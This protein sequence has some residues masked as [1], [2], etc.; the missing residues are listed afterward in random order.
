M[1][2][3]M[4]Q[5][6]LACSMCGQGFTRKRSANRHNL[7]LHSGQALVVRTIEY[8]IG[9]VNGTFPAAIDPLLFRKAHKRNH[10]DNIST[11]ARHIYAHDGPVNNNLDVNHEYK[12]NEKR[13]SYP[14]QRPD[15]STPLV[16]EESFYK[17][18]NEKEQSPHRYKPP[19]GVSIKEKLAE[20]KRLSYEFYAYPVA[21]DIINIIHL[22][23]FNFG[24]EALLDD[25]LN[26]L[27]EFKH[28]L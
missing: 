4:A 9:R 20:L 25:Q 22:R 14:I 23:V 5:Q 3:I 27:R 11:E 6:L 24:D 17:A 19:E 7:N 12:T 28:K 8:V 13:P 2:D 16:Q 10:N 15:L 21:Q 26:W 18:V 1:T